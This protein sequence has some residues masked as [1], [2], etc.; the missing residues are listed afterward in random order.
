LEIAKARISGSDKSLKFLAMI[1]YLSIQS[2]PR[3][4]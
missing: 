1:L 3:A 2:V 4:A